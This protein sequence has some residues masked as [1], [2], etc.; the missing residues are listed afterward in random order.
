MFLSKTRTF[1]Q[2][3]SRK[4]IALSFSLYGLYLRFVHFAQRELWL[5]EINHIEN[6]LGP[7]KPFWLR[8]T[9]GER[10]CFPGDYL[11]TYPFIQLF[12]DNKWGM[13]IPDIISTVLGF[14]LLFLICKRYFNTAWGYLITFVI[15]CF[16]TNL[17]LH[18]FELRPYAI[19]PTLALA[20]FYFSETIVC[21]PDTV[22]RAK[23][24]LV[25]IFFI[26]TVM[27]HAYG[28]LII[29]CCMLFFI[30]RQAASKPLREVIK[31]IWSFAWPVA[32]VA[33]PVFI[34]YATG[35]SNL[36]Y[37]STSAAGMNTFD[38][39]PNPIADLNRFLRTVF[40]NMMGYKKFK[41]LINGIILALLLPHKARYQQAGFF[42][43]L[44]ILPIELKLLSDLH[45]GY[46]FIQRQFVWIMP[47]YAFFIGWCWDASIT[48][49][50]AKIDMRIRR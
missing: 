1:L 41:P 13:A 30:L 46:W 8:L 31:D 35:K 28:I 27:Y 6:T 26:L 7:L 38:Y 39:I 15:A 50:W 12:E 21:R 19:L 14:Y 29:V 47:L 22:T 18:S 10:T 33:L 40:G 23:R 9:Y 2:K 43:L 5:D 49:T 37:A 24:I 42:F 44:I 4:L 36:S 17:I 25:G 20:V 16:N 34:W 3:H 32:A 11:L 48:F 45:T